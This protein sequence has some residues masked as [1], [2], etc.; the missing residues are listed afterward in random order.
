LPPAHNGRCRASAR[1]H[2]PDAPH[3]GAAT[4]PWRGG[5]RPQDRDRPEEQASGH[6][7]GPGGGGQHG[8]NK[9][10]NEG[11][12]HRE[13]RRRP[14]TRERGFPCAVAWQQEGRTRGPSC[15]RFAGAR[16][17]GHAAPSRPGKN[18]HAGSLRRWEPPSFAAAAA[19][20]CPP[21]PGPQP[22]TENSRVFTPPA[23]GHGGGAASP[24][25]R[26]EAT[27]PPE[28]EVADRAAEVREAKRGGRGR[29]RGP[30][31]PGRARGAEE[32]A[33]PADP[34]KPRRR[35]EQT[36]RERDNPLCSGGVVRERRA[37]ARSE[38]RR[39]VVL[40]Q[41]RRRE[42]LVEEWQSEKP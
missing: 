37:A 18:R 39:R 31:T 5:R 11:W 23:G 36:A 21:P 28:R 25:I 32:D 41:R 1:Q 9:A 22:R 40:W 16:R 8:R 15:C 27:A 14:A 24:A 12:P 30:R 34:G 3:R 29:S 2:R 13:R 19:R 20:P 10:R 7:C 42:T 17:G 26:G 33:E 4:Y 38:P 35:A 6:G